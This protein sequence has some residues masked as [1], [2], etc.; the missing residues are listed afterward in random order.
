MVLQAGLRA[1]DGTRRRRRAGC[2]GARNAKL[3][4]W[5]RG[6]AAGGL[7]PSGC[8]GRETAFAGHEEGCVADSAPVSKEQA[9]KTI[10]SASFSRRFSSVSA[11]TCRFLRASEWFEWWFAIF[12]FQKLLSAP[13]GIGGRG[14][15][16]TGPPDR[17]RL[18]IGVKGRPG[19]HRMVCSGETSSDK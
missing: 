6:S 16:P 17:K 12:G 11:G 4:W 2:C 14:A 1:R 7:G 13:T 8:G 5:F 9:E 10:K 18:R 15:D 3:Q 19:A